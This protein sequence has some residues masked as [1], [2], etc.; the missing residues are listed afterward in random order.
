MRQEEKESIIE[1]FPSRFG[2]RN[3]LGQFY[4]SAVASF[5][6]GGNLMLYVYT[7]DG[8]AFSKGSASELRREIIEHVPVCANETDS[9]LCPQ[10]LNHKSYCGDIPSHKLA[11]QEDGHWGAI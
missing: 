4:I 11:A 2:L 5:W 6:T 8:L 1:S 9:G 7:E 3:H 10:P